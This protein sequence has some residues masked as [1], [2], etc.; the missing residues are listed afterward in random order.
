MACTWR[1]EIATADQEKI[2]ERRKIFDLQDDQINGLA[3]Q[4]NSSK[5]ESFFPGLEEINL[6]IRR[7]SFDKL[8]VRYERFYR[9]R[10]KI[11]D[12]PPSL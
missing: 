3:V 2:R 10:Q 1:S 12:R 9:N 8:I 11:L 4:K 7:P 6:S 5:K